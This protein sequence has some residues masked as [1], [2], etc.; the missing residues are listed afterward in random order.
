MKT[1]LLSLA[2]LLLVSTSGAGGVRRGSYGG[3]RRVAPVSRSAQSTP[4]YN[5]SDPGRSTSASRFFAGEQAASRGYAPVRGRGSVGYGSV[6]SYGSSGAGGYARGAR[7]FG[8]GFGS[9]SSYGGRTIRVM[10]T[11]YAPQDGGGTTT[12]TP[13]PAPAEPVQ[14]FA[15]PGALIRTAGLE[16]KYGGPS[17]L[18]RHEIAT[19]GMISDFAATSPRMQHQEAAGPRAYGVRDTAPTP[20][21]GWGA[22]TASGGNSITPNKPIDGIDGQVIGG[23]GGT[24]EN[25][26]SN[27][28]PNKG[29]GRN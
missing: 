4:I 21:P 9:G 15:V 29:N 14:G 23:S 17:D 20:N 22:G 25:D 26:P 11:G 12:S 2:S 13:E 16:T 3:G 5:G 24:K 10:G 1:L 7:G 18:G 6:N 19:N 28:N 8:R 27:W